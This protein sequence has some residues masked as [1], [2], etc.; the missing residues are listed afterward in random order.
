MSTRAWYAER[1]A[2]DQMKNH[3]NTIRE[4]ELDTISKN[5]SDRMNKIN[6]M[7]DQMAR[8]PE[9]LVRK[10]MEQSQLD[11]EMLLARVEELTSQLE[12]TRRQLEQSQAQQLEFSNRIGRIAGDLA[13]RNT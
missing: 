11:N 5:L 1:T 3:K 8:R 9:F 6:E 10:E 2:F 12:I 13:M 4:T 7:E